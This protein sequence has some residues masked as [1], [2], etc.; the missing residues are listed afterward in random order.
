MANNQ[1]VRAIACLYRIVEAGER[2]FEV[3]AK[4]VSN[5]GLKV[6]FKTYA[7]QRAHFLEELRNEIQHLGGQNPRGSMRG[8]IH[9][10]RID[11][12]AALTIG[13][14]NRENVVL[15]ETTIGERVAVRTYERMLNRDLPGETRKIVTRQF[16]AIKKV[17]E[18]V[19]RMRGYLGE[20]TV[21]RLFDADK[22]TETAI[23][24]LKKA[25]FDP[26][27]IET[28]AF[29]QE[30]N[31]YEGKGG[32]VVETVVSGACGGGLWGSLMGAA[33]GIGVVLTPGLEPFRGT[34]LQDVWAFIAFALG[35]LTLGAL[36][37][38]ILGVFIGAGILEEDAYLFN[39]SI[40]HG[41]VLLRVRTEN[42]RAVEAALIMR[43]VNSDS[44]H[45]V[46]EASA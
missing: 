13:D 43:Q 7:Q 19:N 36:L 20:R 41:H 27:A 45:G 6:L 16:Y 17:Q 24:A 42:K 14:Q 37:G 35:G 11:I 40:E 3:A 26:D 23:D 25:G 5:R 21:V 22:D 28:T 32:T 10:G 30:V 4:N 44:R 8:V 18:Q 38:A 12:V 15:K 34:N 9:R 1:A 39:Q 33:A 2:G 29:D 46:L 31:L